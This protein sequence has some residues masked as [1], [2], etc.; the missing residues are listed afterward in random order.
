MNP[1][2]IPR[3]ESDDL[4]RCGERGRTRVEK[5]KSLTARESADAVIGE[6]VDQA[7]W[8]DTTLRITDYA[9]IEIHVI[10]GIVH[11]DGHVISLTN[12][13]RVD[14]ALQTIHGILG[15]KNHLVPDDLLLVEVASALGA[16]EHTYQCKF[17][18]LQRYASSAWAR[19]YNY[20]QLV[21]FH[22]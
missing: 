10:E 14:R 12:Q 2:Q 13:H 15:I 21:I 4:F 18:K 16:L 1:D 9:D 19:V 8:R 6:S 17:F 5:H 3:I 11:L 22:R 20:I 7:L